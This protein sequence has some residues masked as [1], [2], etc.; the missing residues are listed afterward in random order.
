MAKIGLKNFMFGTLVQSIYGTYPTPS[1]SIGQKPAK[2]ISC[3]VDITNND[4]KLFADD[5]LAESDTSFQSGTVTIGI[6]DE[7]DEM[8]SI[9]LGHVYN[10]GEVIRSSNDVAPYVGLG[11]IIT[12]MVSGVYKYK[13]EFLYKV[14]FSEPSQDNNTK[15]ENLEFG[16]SEI[17]GQISCLDNGQWSITKTFDAL[18][19]A[20]TYLESFFTAKEQAVVYYNANGGTGTIPF[21][22]GYLGDIIRVNDGSDLTPP[23]G[24]HFI[25]W[26]TNSS[27]TIPD[28]TETYKMIKNSVTL[29]AIYAN[30]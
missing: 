3:K 23:E 11:R 25:G 29:Y 1:Y 8:L 26:D 13:V 2:A 30:D 15:G 19:D 14:R 28:I 16:T 20:Q 17:I 7:N 21:V 12:K 9:L 4:A 5:A 10:N 18:A 22:A 27:A 6:D 24:K